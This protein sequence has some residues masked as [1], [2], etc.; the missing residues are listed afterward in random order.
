MNVNAPKF[1]RYTRQ[2]PGSFWKGAGLDTAQAG[3]PNHH[4]CTTAD[5]VEAGSGGYVNSCTSADTAQAGSGGYV[6]SCTSADTAQAGNPNH[7]SCTT[8]D[9]AQAG[10]PNHHSCTTADTAQAHGGWNIL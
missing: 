7:H 8:A 6:N 9:T 3:N 4:S 1:E 5:T 10:N 2:A